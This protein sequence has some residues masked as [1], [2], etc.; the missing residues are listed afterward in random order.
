MTKR[1][2]VDTRYIYPSTLLAVADRLYA[3]ASLIMPEGRI[4]P[5][6]NSPDK[7]QLDRLSHVDFAHPDLGKFDTFAHDFGFQDAHRTDSAVYYRGWGKDAYAYVARQS[8]TGKKEFLGAAYVAKTEQDFQRCTQLSGA[9]PVR[10]NEGP[11]G[12]Q[13]VSLCSPSGAVMYV[14]F[15]QTDRPIPKKSV[16][17]TEVHKGE[18]NTPLQ[19]GRKGVYIYPI[20][21]PT[22]FSPPPRRRR[23][24][25]IQNR[26]S[27]GSQARS[28]RVPDKDVRRRHRLLHRELQLCAI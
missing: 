12:G 7:I 22:R 23:I 10:D 19:K 5:V 8:Q 20:Q 6:S 28:L 9:S 16:S 3:V 14:L 24:P 26:T 21:I 1:T 4:P 18:Y 27:H 11:G 25:A 2:A 17:A 15:G 13:V